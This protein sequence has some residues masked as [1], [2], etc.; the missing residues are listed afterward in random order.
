M[1]G[2]HHRGTDNPQQITVDDPKQ[3]TAVFQEQ[4]FYVA[5]NGVTIICNAA[6]V[7]IPE[8]STE[9]PRP[10]TQQGSDYPGQCPNQLHQ[11]HYRYERPDFMGWTL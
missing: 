10:K 1:A 6:N 2:R 5:D 11:R 8:P 9:P 4:S 7:V 3:V